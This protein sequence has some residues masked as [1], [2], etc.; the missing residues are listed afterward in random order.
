MDSERV[1]F[2]NIPRD[3]GAQL[4]KKLTGGAFSTQHSDLPADC[5]AQGQIAL[6][7]ATPAVKN[8]LFAGASNRPHGLNAEC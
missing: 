1:A 4:R 8:L 2:E 7:Y 5:Q 3:G 6:L